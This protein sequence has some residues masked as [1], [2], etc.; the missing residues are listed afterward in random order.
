MRV[1]R[2]RPGK[3]AGLNLRK[4]SP[5]THQLPKDQAGAPSPALFR[6]SSWCRR[7]Q[8]LAAGTRSWLQLVTPLGCQLLWWRSHREGD[9]PWDGRCIEAGHSKSGL[10]PTAR[11][12]LQA[13]PGT[14]ERGW[15]GQLLAGRWLPKPLGEIVGSQ[16]V[17][18]LQALPFP[19]GQ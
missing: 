8:A 5:A 4:C 12:G 11:P 2:G 19:S 16:E 14:R 17:P 3:E 15:E 18:A 9:S 6:V 7:C 10:R 13:M 1:C